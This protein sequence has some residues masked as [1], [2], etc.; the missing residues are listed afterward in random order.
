MSLSRNGRRGECVE[1]SS[2]KGAWHTDDGKLLACTCA[3]EPLDPEG[4]AAEGR[5]AIGCE[6]VL[7]AVRDTAGDDAD[8]RLV[9]R[10][11]LHGLVEGKSHVRVGEGLI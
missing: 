8:A 7:G 3:L 6:Q 4:F 1:G 2:R 5:R 9:L 10:D 11:V